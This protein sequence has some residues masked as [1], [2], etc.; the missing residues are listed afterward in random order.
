MGI[1]SW[2]SFKR[3][4]EK[5]QTEK[6]VPDEDTEENQESSP[7]PQESDLYKRT[8]TGMNVLC[9]QYD[10][11]KERTAEILR[12]VEPFFWHIDKKILPE[13]RVKELQNSLDAC[14]L[15]QDKN[16]HLETVM[17][18]LKPILELKEEHAD[19][20]EDA[21]AKAMNEACGF[22]EIN[23]LLSYGKY[24]STIHIHAPAGETVSNKLGLYRDA[25]KKLADIINSDPEVQ[26][27][28]ATS[29]LVAKHPGLFTRFGFKVEDI[30]DEFRQEHF[31]GEEREI[32][33]A[34]I[35]REEF[36]NKFLKK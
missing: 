12:K 18:T 26:E 28:T 14:S 32:K 6:T 5:P 27:I 11:P 24:K 13:D 17:K 8:R 15:I 19:K 34:S 36:L 23:R 10:D 35:S 33:R 30:T 9:E 2:P 7:S 22:T 31:A 29:Y 21:Q 4:A 16:E 25:M 20:F 1:E 3:K